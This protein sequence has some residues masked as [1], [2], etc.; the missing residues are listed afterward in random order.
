MSRFNSSQHGCR[1]AAASSRLQVAFCRPFLVDSHWNFWGLLATIQSDMKP[2]LIC[3]KKQGRQLQMNK[4][5]SILRV[6]QWES[7]FQSAINIVITPNE[8]E[9]KYRSED[10]N[11]HIRM[12]RRSPPAW[13]E[14]NLVVICYRP[15]NHT[16]D[17]S[18]FQR[19]LTFLHRLSHFKSSN[20]NTPLLR[21]VTSSTLLGCARAPEEWFTIRASP[22]IWAPD[23]SLTAVCFNCKAQC[24]KLEG[25]V[26]PLYSIAHL[27]VLSPAMERAWGFAW[28]VT[29]QPSLS[30]AKYDRACC[31]MATGS[32][33][34]LTVFHRSGN[35][36]KFDSSRISPS[37][38]WLFG[39][40]EVGEVIGLHLH[41]ISIFRGLAEP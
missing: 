24:K 34:P 22:C 10:D 2:C 8:A 28:S 1:K 4:P 29:W 17:W 12:I 31:T 15:R 5:R 37:S 9:I 7:T 16:D 23:I 36:W 25:D 18:F 41:I 39:Q 6:Y 40:K 14:E 13:F 26:Q 33:G 3:R 20:Q 27:S 38:K 32:L 11:P 30:F 35:V 19:F 21:P